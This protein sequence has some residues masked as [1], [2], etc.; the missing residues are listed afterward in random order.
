MLSR[1][2]LPDN[3]DWHLVKTLVYRGVPAEEWAFKLKVKFSLQH[4]VSW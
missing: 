1:G 2:E 4:L 3:E